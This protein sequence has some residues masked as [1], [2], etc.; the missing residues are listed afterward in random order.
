MAHSKDVKKNGP[1]SKG[2]SRRGFLK[3]LGATSLGVAAASKSELLAKLEH[4][5]SPNGTL[6][7]KNA[8]ALTLNINGKIHQVKVE[9][10]I[11]LAEVLRDNLGL[12]GT[13]TGCERGAC[14]ACTVIMEGATINACMTLAV[15]A[16]GQKI[17]TI[18]GLES[19]GKLSKLQE[20]FI[21]NDGLQCGF[22]T[23]GIIMSSKNLLDTNPKPQLE[24]VKKAVSGH[25]CRCGTYPKVFE[26][27][28]AAGK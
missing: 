25:I 7:G 18:E 16:I 8:V 5:P 23:P 21:E 10:R 22:C 14:G 13:K 26:S 17:E 12:T 19:D 9:P 27:I 3:G 6:L 20:S 4:A 11:T 2:V 24:E 15:D 28:L 1:I